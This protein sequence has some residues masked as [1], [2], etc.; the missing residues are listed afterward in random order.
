MNILDSFFM[1]FESDTSKLDKGLSES[2]KKAQTLIGALK[3][4][5]KEASGVGANFVGLVGKLAG[6]AGVALS[7]G[8]LYLCIKHTAEQ[9]YQLEK[10]ALQFR[11]TVGAVHEFR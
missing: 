4:V 6:V 3:G 10:L 8:A 5:D 11:S 7:F 1:L 9:Y 2:D